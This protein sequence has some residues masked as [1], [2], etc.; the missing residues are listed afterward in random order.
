MH[1]YNAYQLIATLVVTFCYLF[2]TSNA[3]KAISQARL[4]ES[5]GHKRPLTWLPKEE[6]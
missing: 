1:A 4:K 5:H 3:E 6:V 2:G